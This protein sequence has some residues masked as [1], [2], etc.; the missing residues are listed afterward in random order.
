MAGGSRPGASLVERTLDVLETFDETH[1]RLGLTEIAHRSGLAPAT[2]LR[3]VRRLT[4]RGA[5]ERHD[6]GRYV[7]GPALWDIGLL[8]SVQTGLREVAAPFLQDLQAATRATVHIAQRDGDQILYLDRLSGRTS[9][10]VVSRVGSRLPMHATGVGKVLLAHA[11]DDVRHRV[12]A[13]LTRVTAYT[14]TSP[15]V[16]GRQLARVLREGHATTAE[17]MSLGACSVA[18]PIRGPRGTG[19]GPD[20]VVAALGIVVGSLQQ[21]QRLL[22]ALQVAAEGIR[23]EWGRTRRDNR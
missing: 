11:P 17:E 2:A 8:A 9:V 18:V 19:E 12:L 15:A 6:D 5:L 13:D 20:D 14:I 21:R 10:P 1:R 3:I 4:A 7:I 16:L 22:A 23:R